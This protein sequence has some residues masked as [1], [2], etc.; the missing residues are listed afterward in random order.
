MFVQP[1]Q[2]K[3]SMFATITECDCFYDGTDRM[4][5]CNINNGQCI[6]TKGISGPR[7]TQCEGM[8]H[9][10]IENGT[11]NGTLSLPILFCLVSTIIALSLWRL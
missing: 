11:C 10:I 5:I 3:M 2:S 9:F 6:C 8:G 4:H 7:C 1:C